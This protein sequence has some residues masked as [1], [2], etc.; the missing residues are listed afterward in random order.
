MIKLLLNIFFLKNVL[1][2]MFRD[3][4]LEKTTDSRMYDYIIRRG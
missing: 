2:D 4:F 3:T 1:R